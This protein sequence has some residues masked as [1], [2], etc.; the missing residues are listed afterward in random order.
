MKE[1]I[2]VVSQTAEAKK[3]MVEIANAIAGIGLLRAIA[4]RGA[5]V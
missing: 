2:F 1:T 4:L 5:R 3:A